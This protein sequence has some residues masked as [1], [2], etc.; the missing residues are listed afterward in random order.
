MVKSAH[1]VWTLLET[2][3]SSHSGSG[4]EHPASSDD[5]ENPHS[6]VQTVHEEGGRDDDACTQSSSREQTLTDETT[7]RVCHIHQLTAIFFCRLAPSL[8]HHSANVATGAELL[9]QVATVARLPHY[10]RLWPLT[11]DFS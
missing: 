9:K 7:S 1:I 2:V 10:L 11:R 3:P 5:R 6:K 4:G 8:L